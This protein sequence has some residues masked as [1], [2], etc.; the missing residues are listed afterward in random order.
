MP[1]DVIGKL[2]HLPYLPIQT[3]ASQRHSWCVCVCPRILLPRNYNHIGFVWS[4]PCTNGSRLFE[5][6]RMCM[7]VDLEP[8]PCGVVCWC[9]GLTECDPNRHPYM[10]D[11]A[12]ACRT[13][14]RTRRTRV[15]RGRG[16]VL[17]SKWFVFFDLTL[18]MTHR[19]RVRTRIERNNNHNA[20]RAHG[21]ACSGA[22]VPAVHVA[23]H[24][25]SNCCKSLRMDPLE[26][27]A[28]S[29]PS[30]CCCCLDICMIRVGRV[31]VRLGHTIQRRNET[32]TRHW[33][34]LIN[35]MRIYLLSFSDCWAHTI[36][37]FCL[38]CLQQIFIDLKYFVSLYIEHVVYILRMHV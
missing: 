21:H 25:T 28:Y 6:V 36:W 4:V 22:R 10:H 37:M 32:H 27:D 14:A 9:V 30:W 31:S 18:A 24:R 26:S 12:R 20:G 13:A 17:R 19:Y 35:N 3:A 11:A 1:S 23:S 8:I 7:Y 38:F 16:H 34:F 5:Y 2:Y 29:T 33:S 15:R